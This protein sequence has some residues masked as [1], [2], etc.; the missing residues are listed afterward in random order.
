M[1]WIPKPVLELKMEGNADDSSGYDNH[2][3]VTDATLTDDRWGHPNSAYNF[4]GT[5]AKIACG[6]VYDGVKSILLIVKL[7][8]TTEYILDLDGGTTYIWVDSGTVKGQGIIS[9]TIYVNGLVSSSVVAGRWYVI[10][11]TT[12]TGIN[13]DNVTLGN[14]GANWFDDSLSKLRLDSVEMTQT[15]IEHLANKMMRNYGGLP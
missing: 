8:S 10:Q 2:G 11:I 14:V 1:V 15:Q 3:T 4:N 12:A 13:A 6:D 5:S 7:D 9:P